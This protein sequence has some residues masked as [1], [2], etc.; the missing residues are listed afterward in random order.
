MPISVPKPGQAQERVQTGFRLPPNPILAYFANHERPDP[1]Y[2]GVSTAPGITPHTVA[3]G[4]YT[5][6]NPQTL[7]TQA[8]SEVTQLFIAGEETRTVQII[9]D[10][11]D[12]KGF[13]PHAYG[14][15]VLREVY[16][17]TKI[18]QTGLKSDFSGE[19]LALPQ[20]ILTNL[21]KRLVENAKF[22]DKTAARE[23]LAAAL[24]EG[25]VIKD[26][27]DNKE[28]PVGLKIPKNRMELG[29][30]IYN[31]TIILQQ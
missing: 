7:M 13:R 1:V 4:P 31:T 26:H 27:S 21:A 29:Q 2:L 16:D 24:V 10:L 12:F 18:K 30:A 3:L 9:G 19:Q 11:K 20:T 14:L 25:Y 8:S 28:K 5:E 17:Q 6:L 23:M 15:A 22:A